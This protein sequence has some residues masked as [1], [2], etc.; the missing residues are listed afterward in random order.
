MTTTTSL[1]DWL[2]LMRQWLV[3]QKGTTGITLPFLAGALAIKRGKYTASAGDLR[4][5]LDRMTSNPLQGHFVGVR[6]C[7]NIQAPVLSYLPLNDQLIR[8]CEL[9]APSGQVSFAFSPDAMSP[10]GGLD[11][12]C[13]AD[14]IEKLVQYSAPYTEAGT[15]SRV[16]DQKTKSFIYSTFNPDELEFIERVLHD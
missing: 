12:D 2:M 16:Y 13:P 7:G 1:P 3:Q 10:F 8:Q 9:Y 11:C 4:A 15:F 6:R 14:C 5:L